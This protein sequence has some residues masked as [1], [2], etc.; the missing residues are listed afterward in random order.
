MLLR[1]AVLLTAVCTATARSQ[2]PS[3]A[4]P[5]RTDTA[6][7]DSVY[8]SAALRRLVAA[9]AALNR[10][11]PPALRGY[12][13]AVETEIGFVLRDTLGREFTTQAEQLASEAQWRRPGSYELHVVGYRSQSLGAPFSALGLMRSWTV[14]TL[15]GDRL[16]VGLEPAEG[17]S[18]RRG[19]RTHGD[20]VHAVHPLAI[21]RDSYYYYEGGDTITTLRTSYGATPI[22]RVR[23]APRPGRPHVAL[24]LFEGELEIDATR[25]ALVRMRGRLLVEGMPR[26]FVSRL[27]GLVAVAYMELENGQLEGAY[28]LPTYQRT[29]L[30]ANFALFGENRSIFRV[31]SRFTRYT[32][33]VV[34]D[35]EGVTREAADS[36]ASHRRE[37]RVTFAGGDSL[38]RYGDWRAPVGQATA[39][40]NGA[41]F[42]DLAPG[43]WRTTVP[44]SRVRLYPKKL[45][46]VLR[47]DRVEGLYTGLSVTGERRDGS[48][49]RSV[50]M[51]GGYAWTEQTARGG[52]IGTASRGRLSVAARAERELAST[53]DFTGTLS[54]GTAGIGGLLGVDDA[55]YVD[56]RLAAIDLTRTLGAIDGG[57]VQLELGVGRDRADSA[58][59]TRGAIV[60]GP[61]FRANRGVAP[62]KYARGAVMLELHP[63]VTGLFLDPGIGMRLKAEVARGD[64]D[65]SRFEGLLAARRSLGDFV[66]QGRLRGGL[67]LGSAIPPQQMLE[68]GG[69]E[70]LSGYDYKEFGGD[71]AA[72]GRLRASYTAPLLRRPHRVWRGYFVPGLSPGLLVGL[73]GGWADAST[74]AARQALTELGTTAMDGVLVPLSRPTGHVRASVDLRLTLF[75]GGISVGAAHPVDHPGPWRAIFAIGQDL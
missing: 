19:G 8:A 22:V 64:L 14:P 17:P 23:V 36:A 30:Q 26:T 44:R 27:P 49:A 11:P 33:N 74:A 66:L 59:L 16:D 67:V 24:A 35:S 46:D 3:V 28:W 4:Q 58:R 73:D 45:D 9:A 25:L 6:G 21:D 53:N 42:D 50:R 31:V 32:L 56:R 72:L 29:E 57:F 61:G 2:E 43:D 5:A 60:A 37:R 52:V 68:V 34:P 39:A 65:W 13:A 38:S 55:D 75:G 48:G 54:S 71:R 47:Y 62:G 63:N 40:V 7:G 15:Y 69:N 18:A 10:A 20:T 12:R 41:D 1:V 70:G 51:F